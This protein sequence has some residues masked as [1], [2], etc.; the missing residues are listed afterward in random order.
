MEIAAQDLTADAFAPFG[1]IVDTPSRPGDAA[2]P[3][4]RWWAET[5]YLPAD[6]C[7][8]GIGYLR[9]EPAPLVFDWAERHLRTVEMIVP[10]QGSCLIHVA[11]ANPVEEIDRKPR[12]EDF[13]VFRLCPGQAV[14][15]HPGVWHAAPLAL[16]EQAAVLV[17]L[18]QNTGREDVTVVRFP[19][20]P[21]S[22][23]P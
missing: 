2:G 4:W 21:V 22:I 1:E 23:K 9:L 10:M 16:W 6:G 18:R 13:Q 11:P 20:T 8:Y 3:G 19:E 14:I 5:A 15:L 12:L 7:P 17:L